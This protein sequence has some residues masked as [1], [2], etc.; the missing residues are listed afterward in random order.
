MTR[1]RPVFRSD[2]VRSILPKIGCIEL[3]GP[4]PSPVE[5]TILGVFRV[6]NYL[7]N[8]VSCYTCT[9]FWLLFNKNM[10]HSFLVEWRAYSSITKGVSSGMVIILS[11]H[12]PTVDV[13][14]LCICESVRR[15][16]LRDSGLVVS[17]VTP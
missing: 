13:G 11:G 16:L 7:F 10:A 1:W 9:D 15:L 12:C 4:A 2:E 14:M 17:S 3:Y 6:V 5:R 8:I